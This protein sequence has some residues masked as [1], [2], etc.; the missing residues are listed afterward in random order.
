M[1]GD[2]TSAQLVESAAPRV[3]R[4][5]REKPELLVES[6]DRRRRIVKDSG[7]S[8]CC[9]T[10]PNASSHEELDGY[11]EGGSIPTLSN[12]KDAM[13]AEQ[14]IPS[15]S[16]TARRKRRLESRSQFADTALIRLS[17]CGFGAKN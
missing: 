10:L 5:E 9:S 6:P 1:E 17:P 4:K 14:T 12:L 15:H 2:E 8:T 13:K 7:E 3:Q 16:G 11:H